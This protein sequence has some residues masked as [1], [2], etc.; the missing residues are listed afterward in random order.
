MAFPTITTHDAGGLTQT[1]NTM[2]DAGQKTKAES[3]SVVLASDSDAMPV[4]VTGN[5][6]TSIG[7]TD[8][9]SALGAAAVFTGTSR[10]LGSYG[11][12]SYYNA[13]AYAD[14]AGTLYIDWSCDAGTTWQVLNSASVA[15]GASVQ[16][17]AALV[18]FSSVNYYRVRFVNGAAAQA[19]FRLATS[20][21]AN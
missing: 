12:F 15:A 10:I 11:Q 7:Y 19:T 2:P 20:F 4:G 17:S 5:T 1:V 13:S 14:V 18:G 21:T 16:L 8:S 9:T 3:L 6:N